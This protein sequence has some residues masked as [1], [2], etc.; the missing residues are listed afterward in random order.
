MFYTW[1]LSGGGNITSFNY[2]YTATDSCLD[3]GRQPGPSPAIIMTAV[4]SVEARQPSTL[5]FVRRQALPENNQICS[6][7]NVVLT[8][9]VPVSSPVSSVWSITSGTAAFVG[10]N[11]GSSVT[12]TSSTPGTFTVTANPGTNACNQPTFTVTVLANPILGA[13]YRARQ[14]LSR[15]HLCV[16]GQFQYNGNVYVEYHEWHCRKPWNF[17]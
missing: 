4:R 12:L 9:V 15:R 3:Y 2:Q 5:P 16:R 13:H 8:S 7:A 17:Q 14:Y 6:G 11:T 1:S 10:G